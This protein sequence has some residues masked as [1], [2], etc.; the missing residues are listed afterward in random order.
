MKKIIY[1]V[2]VVFMITGLCLG[3][4]VASAGPVVVKAVSYFSKNH[5]LMKPTTLEFYKMINEGLKGQVEIKYV[6]GP[7]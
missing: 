1:S 2:L 3:V 6:G 7:E 4:N 5:P